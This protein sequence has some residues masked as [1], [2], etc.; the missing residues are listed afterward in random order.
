MFPERG[1]TG[2]S[3]HGCGCGDAMHRLYHFLDGEL[4]DDRRSMIHRHLDECQ[5]CFQAF[6]FEVELRGLIARKC[7]DQVPQA[8][9][10]RVFHAIQGEAGPLEGPALPPW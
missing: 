5:P 10:D 4:D 6:G 9:R 1:S 2:W 8:L 7:R 3:G